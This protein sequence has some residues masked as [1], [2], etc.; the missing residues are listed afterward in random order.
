MASIYRKSNP[1]VF[2]AAGRHTA[3]VIFAHG[4]GDTGHGWASAVENWRRRQRLDEVKFILPH[5]PPIPITANWGAVMPG[6]FDIKALDGTVEA[7]RAN[8]DEPGVRQSTQYFH[9]LI[10]AEID[11]GIPSDRIILGGFSQGGAMSLFAGLTSPHR[12]AGVLGLSCWLV[13]SGRFAEEIK[14]PGKDANA[15]TPV[16]MAHGTADPVVPM[17][18]GRMSADM[19][20]GLGYDVDLKLYPGLPHSAALE[21]LDDIEAWL[22]RRLPAQGSQ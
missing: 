13:L 6:W 9:E 3:T 8:E 12:L 4:L 10:Q 7:I 16:L 22:T 21:E 2:P 1:L 11:A 17:Q 19:L 15:R 5:A 14:Q 20:K 18:L